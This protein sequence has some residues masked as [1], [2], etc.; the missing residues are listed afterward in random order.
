MNCEVWK[1]PRQNV[2]KVSRD[3]KALAIN[4]NSEKDTAFS[5][6]R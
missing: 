3:M 2:K 4:C 1:F 5:D 6:I